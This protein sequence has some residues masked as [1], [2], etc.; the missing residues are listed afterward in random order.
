MPAR[1]RKVDSRE[2]VQLER[3]VNWLKTVCSLTVVQARITAVRYRFSQNAMVQEADA[4]LPSS[5]C[6]HLHVLRQHSSGLNGTAH[7]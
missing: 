3:N 4:R 7:L 6:T 1:Q 2:L 5:C